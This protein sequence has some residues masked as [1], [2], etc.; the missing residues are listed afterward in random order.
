[1]SSTRGVIMA[2]L[3]CAC[4]LI[5]AFIGLG[6]LRQVN[7][8][9]VTPSYIQGCIV[10]DARATDNSFYQLELGHIDTRGDCVDTNNF[11]I[12]Y[13]LTTG[14]MTP[15]LPADITSGVLPT[16]EVWYK[17]RMNSGVCGS[18]KHTCQLADV[19]ALRTYILN[20]QNTVVP[21]VLYHSDDFA[22]KGDLTQAGYNP[23]AA[24]YMKEG[25]SIWLPAL[26][27]LAGLLLVG[28]GILLFLDSR[29]RQRKT[30]MMATPSV[31]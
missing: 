4:G 16:I 3:V 13:Q 25:V 14:S 15:I 24:T 11:R 18:D 6:S 1:M 26:F 12:G 21:A 19:V 29:K 31:T 28:G 30:E 23:H 9:T 10:A 8:T 5:F 27:L 17:P 7:N 20:Q 22:V 2:I